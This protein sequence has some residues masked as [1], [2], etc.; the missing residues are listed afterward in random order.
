MKKRLFAV[1]L[2]FCLLVGLMPAAAFSVGT[3][4]GKAI[5]LGTSGISGYA[6]TKSYDYIYFG[7][8]EAPDTYTTSGP[9]KWRV[10]DTKTNMDGA[11]EGDGLF[12]L[13]DV[14]FGTGSYGGVYFDDTDPYSNAWQGSYAQS[15]CRDFAGEA[16]AESNVTDAFT[17]GE[18]GAVLA[19]TKSDGAYTTRN[20]YWVP[21]AA[22]ENILNGD[23]VFFLSAQEAENSAYGFINYAACAACYGD[24]EGWWPLRS[25]HAEKP[26]YS[27][28]VTVLEGVYC[29]YVRWDHA[30]RPA[31]NLNQNSVLFTSAAAGGKS[32]GTVGA[33]SLQAVSDYSGTEWKLT[34]LDTSRSFLANVDGQASGSASAGDSVQIT[35][36]GAQTGD[37]EY[38]SVLLCD[39]SDNVLYYGNIAQNSESGTE[40]VTIPSGLATGSYTLKVFSEQCNGDY[41]TDYASTFQNIELKI[42][43]LPQEITPSAVFTATGDNGGTLSNVDT[44]MKYSVDGGTNWNAI[45]GETMEITGVTTENGIKIY[46]QGNGTT[47]SDSEVQTID[48]TQAAQPTSIGKTDCT[49]PQQNDGQI[50]GVDTTMEYRTSGDSDWTAVTENPVTGLTN[51]T[52]E[53]RVKANGTV[54]ASTAA[55]VTIGA[56]TCAAQDQWQYDG[57]NHWKFCTCG[58]KVEE[59]AHSGGTATCMVSAVCEVC[60]QPYGEKNP[61]NHVGTEAWITT[62]TTHTK[63]YSCCQ[64]VIETETAHTW[65]NGKC[66]VCQYDCTHHGGTATCS[67][68][69]QCEICG[70]L[71]GSYDQ[72]NHKAADTWTPEIGKH[73]HI[74]EYGC[75]THLDEAEHSAGDW[76]T[77]TA[78]TETTDGTKHKECTVCGYV[79]ETGTIPA[80]GTGHTHSYGESWKSDAD[81]HWHECSCGDKTDVA[82]HTASDWIIDTAATETTD[83]TKHKECTICGYVLETGT[84]PATGTGH[85]HS[86]GESWKS[87]AGNHWHACSCGDKS[88]VAAHSAQ[89]DGNCLTAV[90]CA[91]CGYETKAAETSHS[92]TSYTSNNDA[93]CTTDGTETAMC[94]HDG[95]T[96]TDTRTDSGSA[97]GHMFGDWITV[98]SPTCTGKGAQQRTCSECGFKETQ[99]VNPNGHTWEDNYTVDKAATCT[100]DGSKSIH[101]K[102]CGVVKD[103]EVIPKTGHKLTH[104]PAKAAT[105]TEDGNIEYWYCDVCGKYFSDAGSKTEITLADTVIKATG[106]S[107]TDGKCTVCGATD[108]NYTPADSTGSGE[109]GDDAGKGSNSPQTGDNSNIVLWFSLM[110][111]AGTA[112]AGTAV[113]ARKKKCSR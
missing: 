29:G 41:K 64:A 9:I 21:F 110:L 85:T 55:T 54:L 58:A 72:S 15:W 78:A 82:A 6:A 77:D 38:V 30:V 66:S 23:K 36:S 109:Q 28:T 95:C 71:Y 83:G 32:S 44:S 52:Y 7:Y 37:N 98:S 103:S 47:T 4:T 70:S 79:L 89:D 45:T 87:D 2:C 18:L 86:Y 113:Y 96:V 16:G 17:A 92:F 53:I 69:A 27:G 74:C 73:Y 105:C 11:T 22:S 99:D 25:P 88:D 65:E 20:S 49:T 39:N 60:G 112:L 10:L 102:N 46:K 84:I 59:A 26:T 94:N 93:S 19:T 76:I 34:L 100:E 67:Q 35:Y 48:V 40:S 75:S 12:L 91:V 80:T 43:G 24:I 13:S 62:G 33:G 90:T 97:N 107:Y 68:L 8:W 5:Q 14:L 42:A 3:D 1:L 51:G 111:A 101:C 57:A 56:H 61:D 50:T 63:V 108:P 31:F 106:H 81:D 104:T